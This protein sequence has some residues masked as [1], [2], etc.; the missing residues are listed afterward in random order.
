M[1]NVTVHRLT[2]RMKLTALVYIILKIHSKHVSMQNIG[3][4]DYVICYLQT[5]Y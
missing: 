3:Y 5:C 2:A 1:A 4:I